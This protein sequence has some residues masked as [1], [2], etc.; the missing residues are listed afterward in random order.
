MDHQGYLPLSLISGFPRVS[1]VTRDLNLIAM[2]VM[3][4]EKV[5]LDHT[6]ERVSNISLTKYLLSFF[7]SERVSIQKFGPWNCSHSS[8]TMKAQTINRKSMCIIR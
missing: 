7:R 6:K 1:Q 3:D 4:S 8:A 2:A 5:E